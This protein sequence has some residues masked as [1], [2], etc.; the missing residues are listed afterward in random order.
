MPRT[1]GRFGL[2]GKTVPPNGEEMRFQRTVRPTEP[3][4]SVAPMTATFFGLKMASRG[5]W[6]IGRGADLEVETTGPATD[7][8][9]PFHRVR[10]KYAQLSIKRTT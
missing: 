7:M 2:T 8:K 1:E 3:V 4:C 6:L 5:R 10:E 9:D